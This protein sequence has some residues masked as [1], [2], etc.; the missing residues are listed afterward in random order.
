LVEEQ[1]SVGEGCLCGPMLR[2]PFPLRDQGMGREAEEGERG[3]GAG[4]EH[5]AGGG[6]EGEREGNGE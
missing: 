5:G 2:H 6:L 1:S 3:G 4:H